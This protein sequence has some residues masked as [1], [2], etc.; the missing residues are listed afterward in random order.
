MN[1]TELWDQL[2]ARHP[3]FTDPDYILRQRSRGL[4]AIIFQAYD[5]GYKTGEAMAANRANQ[6]GPTS[7]P[8]QGLFNDLFNK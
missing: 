6:T 8:F 5:E 4:R 7:N 1:K 3:E 2:V